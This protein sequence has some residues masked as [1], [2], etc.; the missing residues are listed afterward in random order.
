MPAMNRSIALVA[1]GAILVVGIVLMLVPGCRRGGTGAPTTQQGQHR[2][3]V[4]VLCGGSMRAPIEELVEKYGAVCGDLVRVSY[5]D[6]ADLCSQVQ[7]G[8][9]GDIFV[10]HDPFMDWA[11]KQGR[12]REWKPVGRLALVLVA[13]KDGTKGIQGVA[14]LAKGGLRIGVGDMTY[15][16]SGFI[17]KGMLRNHPDGE[18]IRKNI[19]FET[20]SHRELVEAVVMGNL[21]AALTWNLVAHLYADRLNVFAL[22]EQYIDEVSS[23]PDQPSN[24]RNI[25][26]SVGILS[27]AGD[28]EPVRRFYEFLTKEGPAVFRAHNA[29][30]LRE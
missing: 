4:L 11:A 25:K 14:D 17:V 8:G 19:R 22:P 18:A 10:C 9:K 15:S 23:A 20:R 24:L 28:G 7:S 16:T 3:E 5:G 2:A 12:I 26:I 1:R 29:A 27:M 21:D 6:S 30:P 13:P